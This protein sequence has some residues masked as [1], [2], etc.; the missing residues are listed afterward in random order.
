MKLLTSTNTLLAFLLEFFLSFVRY[1]I[2]L[3]KSLVVNILHCKFTVPQKWCKDEWKNLFLWNF[4]KK[5]W[6]NQDSFQIWMNNFWVELIGG[7]QTIWRAYNLKWPILHLGFFFTKNN[8]G[9]EISKNA[10]NI[11]Q[12]EIYGKT[13]SFLTHGGNSSSKVSDNTK[14]MMDAWMGC[15]P[16]KV[17][18]HLR[19]SS[20]YSW[21]NVKITGRIRITDIW[22]QNNWL[23]AIFPFL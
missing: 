12:M 13:F 7:S 23:F 16:S 20:F 17:E 14:K 22:I 21:W 1:S 15:C 2:Q 5:T 10:Q 6:I 8:P 18:K 11:H 4:S 19:H 3:Y 9:S